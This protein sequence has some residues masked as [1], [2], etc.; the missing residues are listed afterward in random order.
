M[1]CVIWFSLT[2]VLSNFAFASN[3]LD[4]YNTIF[5]LGDGDLVP[6]GN[7]TKAEYTSA[8]KL[9]QPKSPLWRT[10]VLKMSSKHEKGID[11][12]WETL[13]DF[14][15]TMVSH[16]ELGR[17]RAHQQ[18]AWMW[19][20]IQTAMQDSFKGDSKLKDRIQTLEAQVIDGAVYPGVAADILM[21]DFWSSNKKSL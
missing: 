7:R 21:N 15:K 4:Y 17:L 11:E 12:V 3:T 13:W 16:G 2:N 1:N 6:A 19:H 10:Q 14:K 9:I 18:R 5:Y 8:L 20:Y